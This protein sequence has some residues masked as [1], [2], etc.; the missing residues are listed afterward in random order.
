MTREELTAEIDAKCSIAAAEWRK[1]TADAEAREREIEKL[2]SQ[3][4]ALDGAP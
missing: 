4:E 3:R 1:A 2:R